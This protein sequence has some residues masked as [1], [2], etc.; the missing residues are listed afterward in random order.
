MRVF[1]RAVGVT[2]EGCKLRGIPDRPIALS[3][4]EKGS[5]LNSRNLIPVTSVAAAELRIRELTAVGL[6]F[7]GEIDLLFL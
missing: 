5:S 4:S 1:R 3:L 6:R 2:N 7:N